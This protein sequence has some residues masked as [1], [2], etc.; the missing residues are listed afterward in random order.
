VDGLPDGRTVAVAAVDGTVSLV[1]VDRGLLR[2]PPLPVT[3]GTGPSP[4]HLF[5]DGDDVVA[6]SGQDPGR[7]FPLRTPDRLAA[8]CAVVGRDMTPEEWERHLPGREWRP[9][10]TDLP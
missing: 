8:V 3:G 5:P 6:L 10:C 9:T 2:G 4:L 1:D 7:R